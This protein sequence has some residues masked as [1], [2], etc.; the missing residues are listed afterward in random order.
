MASTWKRIY[1]SRSMA[2]LERLMKER[3]RDIVLISLA[4][5]LRRA[6]ST[7]YC[8]FVKAWL[9]YD[10]DRGWKYPG[11]RSFNTSCSLNLHRILCSGCSMLWLVSHLDVDVTGNQVAWFRIV[12]AVECDYWLS[13]AHKSL[14]TVTSTIRE[15]RQSEPLK[16]S[17][18]SLHSRLHPHVR[19]FRD[20]TFFFPFVL[21]NK[22]CR[23]GLE[24]PT[25]VLTNIE[26]ISNPT[27]AEPDRKEHHL[28]FERSQIIAFS[29]YQWPHST[30]L[31]KIWKFIRLSQME[32]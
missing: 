26:H 28:I 18:S 29:M 17:K 12:V 32:P 2:S 15:G 23:L 24:T 22:F 10:K 1:W 4:T 25:S 19:E 9:R 20:D 3:D 16:T 5:T 8:G 6:V 13:I 27:I 21:G 31:Q 7:R 14:V 30:R 11:P